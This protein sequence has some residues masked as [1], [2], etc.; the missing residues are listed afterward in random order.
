[1]EH[2]GAD[3]DGECAAV[4]VAK[5]KLLEEAA[6]AVAEDEGV[7]AWGE[8]GEEV[9]AGALEEGAEGQ[10]F[11][12]AV[13]AGYGVEVGGWGLR[14]RVRGRRRSGVRRTRSAAARRWMGERRWRRAL[15]RRRAAALRAQARAGSPAGRAWQMAA[16]AV[17]R[18][19]TVAAR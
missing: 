17:E 9:G 3:V 19:S 14:H 8:S 13:D 15:S 12:V 5:E 4:R 10:V 11:G 7:V 16:A 6:V 18:T 1:L 2:G